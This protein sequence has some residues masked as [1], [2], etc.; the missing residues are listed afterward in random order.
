[1]PTPPQ[2]GPLFPSPSGGHRRRRDGEGQVP[3]EA[4]L[5]LPYSS[6]MSGKT[7]ELVSMPRSRM[8]RSRRKASSV[9]HTNAG[10]LS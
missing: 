2:A 5:T 10:R 6:L 7:R 9:L 4:R 3:H 1:M 8:P